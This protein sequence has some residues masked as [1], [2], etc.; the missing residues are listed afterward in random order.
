VVAD[1]LRGTAAMLGDIM[2]ETP[3]FISLCKVLAILLA[4]DSV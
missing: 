4:A 3:V 2:K 1:F